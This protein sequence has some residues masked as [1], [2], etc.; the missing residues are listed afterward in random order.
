YDAQLHVISIFVIMGLSF[1]G[2]MLP[3][4]AK[5]TRLVEVV[6]PPLPYLFGVGV[7]LATSLVHMLS[8]GQTTLTNPCLPP[9]FQ[10]YGSWS[11][12]IALLGMLTIHSAQLVARERGGVGCVEMADTIDVEGGEGMPLLH[13]R[14]LVVRK[15]LMAAERRVA[16]F[17]LEAGV[18][19]HSVI[20]G[21]TLGSARAEFNSLFIALCFHQFF[22]GM[23]LS[24]VVLDAE[25]EKKIVA[26]IMVIF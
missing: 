18:A 26:L 1:L 19:S 20:V 23:A 11:G 25:F 15:S 9:L 7:I 4:L 16:T 14:K 6:S 2:T 21:L 17:V 8:P 3:I 10:D 24:S 13:S 22:E 12:A 5:W